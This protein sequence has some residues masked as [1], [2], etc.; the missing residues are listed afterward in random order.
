MKISIVSEAED[1]ILWPPDVKN[2]LIGKD[3]DA[4]RDWK[5]KKR[6][7]EDK[8]VGWQK[9]K[10]T[11]I[12]NWEESFRFP[13]SINKKISGMPVQV[14]SEIFYFVAIL[15]FSIMSRFCIQSAIFEIESQ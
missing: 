14:L 10:K 13:F 11:I 8:M 6:V 1:L 4:G 2:R 5:Q 3:P 9:D 12:V 7:A 15:N